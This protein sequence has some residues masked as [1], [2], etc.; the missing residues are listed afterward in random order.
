MAAHREAEVGWRFAKEHW[1]HGYE[2]EAARAVLRFAAEEVGLTRVISA[3]H[4]D[5]VASRRLAERL[6]F[7]AEREEEVHGIP[8]VYYARHLLPVE[9]TS[10]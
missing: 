1:H 7:T 10:R 3:I 9:P 2:Y 4:P 5:N 8:V 6:G